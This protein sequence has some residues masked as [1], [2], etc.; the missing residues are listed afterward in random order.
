MSLDRYWAVPRG[1]K[2]EATGGEDMSREE[3]GDLVVWWGSMPLWRYQDT[4]RD[5]VATNDDVVDII[6][7]IQPVDL[8]WVVPKSPERDPG[9]GTWWRVVGTSDRVGRNATSSRYNKSHTLPRDAVIV[10][11][12]RIYLA[13]CRKVVRK[14][15]CA[16]KA[17]HSL[18]CPRSTW[19][20]L[21][22]VSIDCLLAVEYH[23]LNRRQSAF[24]FLTFV[25]LLH[26]LQ[27]ILH[28]SRHRNTTVPIYYP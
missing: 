9:G 7:I 10:T 25:M 26:A 8:R 21:V 15:S 2:S 22:G 12:D 14:R 28:C 18:W 17:A 24:R 20:G 11:G 5:H 19:I 23:L 16:V 1:N 4:W 27:K 6:P 3:G 13:A